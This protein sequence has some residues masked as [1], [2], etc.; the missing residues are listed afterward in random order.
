M[1]EAAAQEIKVNPA[2]KGLAVIITNDYAGAKHAELK[3]THK[4]GERMKDAFEALNFDVCWKKN[5]HQNDIQKLWHEIKSF[6]FKL[7]KHYTCMVFVFSGHGEPEGRDGK[8]K[9]IMQDDTKIDIYD[10]FVAPVLPGNANHIGDIPKIFF[11]DACRGDD[12]TETVDVPSRNG[13]TDKG[14]PSNRDS[15][16]SKK[17]CYQIDLQKVPK[18]ANCLVAYSTLPG[19]RSIDLYG[20][21]SLWLKALAKHLPTSRE[22]I[23]VLLTDVNKELLAHYREHGLEFQQPEKISRLNDRLYL[24]G[25]GHEDREYSPMMSLY[26]RIFPGCWGRV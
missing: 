26:Y 17:G 3:G 2:S 23:E 24:L 10:D 12:I 25:D 18:E 22:T 5:V 8:V 21:G 20:I 9:L 4:D 1:A 15:A 14:S 16:A 6:D 13:A 11:I 19:C 7:V